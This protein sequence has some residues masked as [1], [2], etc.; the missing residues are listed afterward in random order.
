MAATRISKTTCPLFDSLRRQIATCVTAVM[1]FAS[2]GC[3]S[4]P[5]A[6]RSDQEFADYIHSQA[7]KLP[8]PGVYE[9][10][11]S[12]AG[13]HVTL[14]GRVDYPETLR[15]AGGAVAKTPRTTHRA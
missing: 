14:G 3:G 5:R 15:E 9:L 11:T 4:I 1:I 8:I 12:A 6:T 10:R 7:E 2:A 13:G